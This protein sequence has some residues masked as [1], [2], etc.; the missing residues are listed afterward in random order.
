MRVSPTIHSSSVRFMCDLLLSHGI[1]G[2]AGGAIL[3]G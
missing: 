1:F 3:S 2:K